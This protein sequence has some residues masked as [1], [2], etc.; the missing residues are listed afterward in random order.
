MHVITG[1]QDFTHLLVCVSEM[2]TLGIFT[3][4]SL[5]IKDFLKGKLTVNVNQVLD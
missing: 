1:V 5:M 3:L 4:S 2:I